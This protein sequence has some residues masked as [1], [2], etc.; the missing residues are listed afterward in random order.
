MEEVLFLN[1]PSALAFYILALDSWHSSWDPMGDGSTLPALVNS[2]LRRKSLEKPLENTLPHMEWVV[3]AYTPFS[4]PR[5]TNT[6]IQSQTL[7]KPTSLFQRRF[8]GLVSYFLTQ[9]LRWKR[10][11]EGGKLTKNTPKRQANRKCKQL[12]PRDSCLVSNSKIKNMKEK[13]FTQK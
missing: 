9:G 5:L 8:S 13:N 3:K 4:W 7:T 6:N 10:G 11:N 2:A 1:K 12:F